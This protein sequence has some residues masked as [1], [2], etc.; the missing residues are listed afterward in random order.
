MME[1]CRIGTK[2][3]NYHAAI[4]STVSGQPL[5]SPSS[6]VDG[7][8][9]INGT[10]PIKEQELKY[11]VAQYAPTGSKVDFIKSDRPSASFQSYTEN[12]IRL[13]GAAL[14]L[15]MGFLYNLSGL[16]GPAA[17]MDSQ[18]AQRVIEWHQQNMKERVL[19]KVKNTYIMDGIAEGKIPYNP[20]WFRGSWQF[21]P[22]LS[23]DV[24]RD[25]AA[26]INEWRAGLRSKA[27]WFNESGQDSEEVEAVITEESSRTIATAKALAEEHDI[28]F[29]V[30][31]NILET[32]TPNGLFTNGLPPEPAPPTDTTAPTIAPIDPQETEMARK[33]STAIKELVIKRGK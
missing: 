14:N 9:I 15:P 17:R 16:G 26:G 7:N 10:T 30:A 33:V 1:A 22:W 12:L 25:S 32:R 23:I 20:N 13:M 21:P 4:I 24:G 3:E 31:Y 28:P 19:E 27:D 5:N 18:Q 2:F 6:Y 11:G 8:D 29:E